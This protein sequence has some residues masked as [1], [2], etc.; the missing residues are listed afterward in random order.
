MKAGKVYFYYFYPV[1]LRNC[2]IFIFLLHLNA[3]ASTIDSLERII[4]HYKKVNVN[5]SNLILFYTSLIHEYREVDP[6]KGLSIAEEAT[7]YAIKCADR[8]G[9]SKIFNK[10]GNIYFDLGLHGTA[11]NVYNQCLLINSRLGDWGAVAY[12]HNDIGYVYHKRELYQLALSQ[13]KQAIPFVQNDTSASSREILAHTYNNIAFAF[14]KIGTTDSSALYFM[15]ALAIRKKLNK[16]DK[17]GQS[18]AY[19]GQLATQMHR[20]QLAEKYLDDAI[21]LNSKTGNGLYLAYAWMYKGDNALKQKNYTAALS[22][23]RRSKQILLTNDLNTHIVKLAL[24]TG[25]VLLESNRLKEAAEEGNQAYAQAVKFSQSTEKRE[26]LRL[27]SYIAMR[28][29]L[30]DEIIR[31]QRLLI[32]ENNIVQQE[33]LHST[34]K[35][36]EN[37]QVLQNNKLSRVIQ[38]KND[39][40]EFME[41][42]SNTQTRQFLIALLVFIILLTIILLATINFRR[43]TEGEYKKLQHENSLLQQ[44]SK[45]YYATII[46]KL[47]EP[48]SKHNQLIL[49]LSGKRNLFSEA[50]IVNAINE[51]EEVIKSAELPLLNVLY[52]AKYKAGNILTEADLP[53]RNVAEHAIQTVEKEFATRKIDIINDIDSGIRVKSS[54]GALQLIF[55]NL[56]ENVILHGGQVSSVRLSAREKSKMIEVSLR[57]NGEGIDKE[58]VEAFDISP[59]GHDVFEG[60]G[61]QVCKLICVKTGGD[62]WVESSLGKGN[63]VYFTLFNSTQ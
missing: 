22:H 16:Q 27:L 52:W 54:K 4:R 39:Y 30:K 55:R 19:L 17:I 6:Y 1:L 56:L 43:K 63:T 51:S 62:L 46:N 35:Q 9:L 50:D 14:E 29:G 20:Y 38:N 47:Q 13:Y 45:K 24:R 36:L 15:K 7:G 34:I 44:E 31:Y 28:S 61:L 8:K 11:V 40:I 2:L 21:A 48:V 23:F 33:M 32:D 37:N 25:N 12:T 59:S 58:L 5:D 18:L 60:M 42:Q 10:T 49:A 26:A 53:L 41:K 3:S 57:D